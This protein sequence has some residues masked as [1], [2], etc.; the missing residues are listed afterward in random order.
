MKSLGRFGAKQFRQLAQQ[1]GVKDE[2]IGRIENC[3]NT[4]LATL[5]YETSPQSYS[6]SENGIEV[7]D[8]HIESTYKGNYHLLA[9]VNSKE[10]KYIIRIGHPEHAAITTL[11]LSNISED[12]I[13][14][15]VREYILS[16]L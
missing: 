14:Q 16:R 5:G 2:W 8:A 4:H 15:L 13:R 3:I 6:Y 9:T 10:S 11:G 1:N 7:A 12:K